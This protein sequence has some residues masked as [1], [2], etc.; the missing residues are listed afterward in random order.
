MSEN[1]KIP[2]LPS[3][4]VEE[5]VLFV[6]SLDKV[7]HTDP[8]IQN[9]TEFDNKKNSNSP[10][11]NTTQ[12][13]FIDSI[14]FNPILL[15]LVPVLELTQLNFSPNSSNSEKKPFF[16]FPNA[17]PLFLRLAATN[18]NHPPP[19]SAKDDRAHLRP[20]QQTHIR[21]VL[22]ILIAQRRRFRA[23][24]AG[25]R[26]PSLRLCLLLAGLLL[27]ALAPLRFGE[28]R[29]VRRE[30]VQAGAARDR[31]ARGGGDSGDVHPHGSAG[32]R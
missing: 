23:L 28:R 20:P 22:G 27:A 18:T 12:H 11:L 5:R 9:R 26:R 29:F 8:S 7:N 2:K 4:D 19:I 30:E 31:K 17:P 13:L 32:V 6:L 3:V 10:H 21:N 1:L 15:L 14:Q 24:L 16:L 25:D